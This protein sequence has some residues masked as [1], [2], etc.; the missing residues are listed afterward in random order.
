MSEG[1]IRAYVDVSPLLCVSGEESLESTAEMDGSGMRWQKWP[2][3]DVEDT[4]KGLY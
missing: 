4:G 2:M 3:Y 1:L